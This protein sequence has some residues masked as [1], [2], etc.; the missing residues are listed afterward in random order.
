[1]AKDKSNAESAS[2]RANRGKSVG[3]I[4]MILT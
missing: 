2:T 1:M 4:Q 3:K